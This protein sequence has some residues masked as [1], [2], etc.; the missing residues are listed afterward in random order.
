MAVARRP[1][2]RAVVGRASLLLR[3]IGLYGDTHTHT[4]TH[5]RAR[6]YVESCWDNRTTGNIKRAASR[7]QSVA[8]TPSLS[9]TLRQEVQILV[10]NEG[11]R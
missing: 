5:R 9:K 2:D 1:Q 4:Y 6:A 3:L 8:Q 10:S 11:Q 7:R